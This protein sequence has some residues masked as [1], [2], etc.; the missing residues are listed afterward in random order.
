MEINQERHKFKIIIASVVLG[1]I[2]I[3]LILTSYKIGDA[4]AKLYSYLSLNLGGLFLISGA[5]SLISE[6]YLKKNFAEQIQVSIN[7]KLERIENVESISNV[8]LSKIE[9]VFQKEKLIERI[10]V[11]KKVVMFSLINHDFFN[12]YA[13]ELKDLIENNGLTLNINLFNYQSDSLQVVLNRF[14]KNDADNLSENI[15]HV[16]AYHLKERIHDQLSPEKTNNINVKLFDRHP[17]YSA[18]LFDDEEYWFVPVFYRKE[19]RPVP[20]FIFNNNSKIRNTEFYKDLCAIE[21]SSTKYCLKNGD[22]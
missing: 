4:N 22:D 18:Y 15:K 7:R 16:L 14:G 1:A 17:T 20:V 9:D 12:T 6:L 19:R 13:P 5:Y 21:E 3:I 11:S 10:K 2:G 8:G